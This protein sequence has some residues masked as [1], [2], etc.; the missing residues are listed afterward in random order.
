[1]PA[2]KPFD[3][4]VALARIR[5]AVAAFPHAALFELR[6][7][8]FAS[9]FEQLVACL[10]SIRTYDETMIEAARRLFKIART[11][12]GVLKLSP[13]E[14]AALIKPATFYENKACQIHAIA[15]QIVEEFEGGLPCDYEV[16]TSLKGIGPKC[17]NL[18]LGIACDQPRIGVDIHVY[19]VTNRWGYIAAKTPEASTLQLEARLPREYWVTINELLVPF[20]K[21]IC[22]GK[23]PKCSTCPV[24]EMCQQV[25]VTEHR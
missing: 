21:H 22:T 18:V 12:A 13:A 17:A 14:I 8:G 10:I 11:P 24:L 15:H 20:G 1:M 4:D 23:L 9:A 16:L 7:E 25:G 6:D 2:K 3:V 5:K 19:R